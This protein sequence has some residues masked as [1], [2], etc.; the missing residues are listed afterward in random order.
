M[1]F[2]LLH[3]AVKGTPVVSINI[4][5]LAVHIQ[6]R[7]RQ[8]HNTRILPTAICH[9]PWPSSLSPRRSPALLQPRRS[10]HDDG[11]EDTVTDV[12]TYIRPT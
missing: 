9:S 8:I 10:L 7:S 5:T 6:L 11:D 1:K 3:G 2:Q 4:V 12:Q